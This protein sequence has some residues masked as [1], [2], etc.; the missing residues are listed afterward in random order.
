MLRGCLQKGSPSKSS[1]TSRK[2]EEIQ[3]DRGK[4]G[5]RSEQVYKPIH[6]EEVSK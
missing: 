5:M 3:A 6:E 2:E 1:N 4:D